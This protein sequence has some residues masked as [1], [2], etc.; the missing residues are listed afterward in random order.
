[1]T[2]ALLA[3][4]VSGFFGLA[5]LA[6]GAYLPYRWRQKDNAGSLDGDRPNGTGSS[7]APRP[8]ATR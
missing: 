1:M 5:S 3:Q 7:T 2:E 4:V 8:E 6:L